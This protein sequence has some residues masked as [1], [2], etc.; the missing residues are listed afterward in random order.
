M[1][2]ENKDI[3]SKLYDFTRLP[4]GQ[5]LMV[6]LG[7]KGM[8]INYLL[9]QKLV[10]ELIENRKICGCEFFIKNKEQSQYEVH[11]PDNK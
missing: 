5:K 1:E 4:E 11:K 8:F 2:N 7:E 10:D 9:H 3:N 6:N